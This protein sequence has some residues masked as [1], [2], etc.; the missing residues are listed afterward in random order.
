M[1][2]AVILA[3]V[4]GI[5]VSGVAT[6]NEDPVEKKLAAAKGEYQKIVEN[7]RVGLTADLKKKAEAVQKAGDLKMLE[8][9]EAEIKALEE[10]GELAKSVKTDE[11]VSTVRKARAKLGSVNVVGPVV[12]A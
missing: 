12:A 5:F 1:N 2:R 3:V 10:K 9:V 7:V 4:W 11:Y 6:A 8:K